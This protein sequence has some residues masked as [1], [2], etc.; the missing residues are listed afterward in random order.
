MERRYSLRLA[1]NSEKL[2]ITNQSK[3]R[4]THEHKPQF[5]FLSSNTSI[6]E[7]EEI[8]GQEKNEE[9]ALAL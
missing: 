7:V 8:Q 4:Q 6:K 1:P 5:P 3:H 2:E 9:Q